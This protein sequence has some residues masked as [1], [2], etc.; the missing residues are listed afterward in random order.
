MSKWLK[1]G[2]LAMLLIGAG[3]L[4][5]TACQRAG[6]AYALILNPSRELLNPLLWFLLGAGAVAVTAGVVAALIRPV[7]LAMIAFALS[8]LA[9]LL[10]WQM[11]A[12]S[13]IL[14]LVY[15]LTASLYAVSVASELDQRISFAVQPISGG[16]GLLQMAIILLACG[17]LYADAAAHIMQE[18][19]SIPETYVDAF[20]EQAERQ[21]EAR[22]PEDERQEVVAEFREEF[23][24]AVDEFFEQ[25]VKPREH[26]IPLALAA[27]LFTPLVTITRLLAWVPTVLLS[28]IFRLLRAL[29]VTKVVSETR[30]VQRLTID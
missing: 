27:S 13:G 5:G 23:N 1:V 22:V 15:V 8:G 10:G 16:Q 26:L 12:I 20:M 2:F 21:I 24:R 14:G 4:L 3:Y 11:T 9:M 19:F 6:R 7:W 29:G 17:G 30:E 18:G 25:T 28:I